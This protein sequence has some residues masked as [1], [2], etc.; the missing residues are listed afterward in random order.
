MCFMVTKSH[1]KNAHA[2]MLQDLRACDFGSMGLL[3]T[4]TLAAR[5]FGSEGH[6]DY[7]TLGA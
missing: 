6:M 5:D 7:R 3:E 4:V 1:A 2:P